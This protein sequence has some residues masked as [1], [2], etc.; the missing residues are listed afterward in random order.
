[1][2]AIPHSE[3]EN[4]W[5]VG[6]PQISVT[7]TFDQEG[8]AILDDEGNAVTEEVETIINPQLVACAPNDSSAERAVELLQSEP[9]V[10]ELATTE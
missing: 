8:N 7:E 2:K 1:M 5:L 10:E 4:H 3:L 6:E 9:V